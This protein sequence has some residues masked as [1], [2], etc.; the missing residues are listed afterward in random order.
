MAG[1]V[2]QSDDVLVQ[3]ETYDEDSEDILDS[4][5]SSDDGGKKGKGGNKG[6]GGGGNS[7]ATIGIVLGAIVVIVICVF[8]MLKIVPSVMS[9][10]SE[11]ETEE[12]TEPAFEYM[13][14]EIEQLRDNG[15]TGDEIESYEAESVPAGVLIDDAI[16]RR[17]SLYEEEMR[18]YQDS[19]S[20]EYKELE[21]LTWLGGDEFSYNPKE[22]DNWIRKGA[23]LNLDYKKVPLCGYQCFIRVEIRK[24][25]VDKG[26]K[27]GYCFMF[28]DPVRYAELPEEGNI[29]VHISYYL[30]EETNKSIITSI[31]EERTTDN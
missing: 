19:K 10:N 9:K 21:A 20:P 11:E 12:W 17:E 14:I 7:A 5:D 1:L 18:P 8:G 16:A 28:I 15:Y 27:P 4:E 22:V 26:I 23:T 13:D 31:K 6:G 24:E 3:G 2:N 30:I 25:N 29:N